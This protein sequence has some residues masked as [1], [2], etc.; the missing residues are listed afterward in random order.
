VNWIV[1]KPFPGAQ[2]NPQT[3][4][5]PLKLFKGIALPYHKYTVDKKKK[6]RWQ[7]KSVLKVQQDSKVDQANTSNEIQL[8]Q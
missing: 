1:T 8:T 6:K 5:S 7:P 3:N 4:L 2:T